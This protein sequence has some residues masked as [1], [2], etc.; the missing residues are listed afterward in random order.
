MVMRQIGI[1]FGELAG[2][3]YILPGIRFGTDTMN[4]VIVQDQSKV[5]RSVP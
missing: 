4:T 2:M 3:A 1:N 5:V